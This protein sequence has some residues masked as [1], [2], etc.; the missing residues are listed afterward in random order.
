MELFCAD[1]VP[2]ATLPWQPRAGAFCTTV[3]CKLTL[4]LDPGEMGLAS[5]QDPLRDADVYREGGGLLFASDM[6]PT[7][8]RAD[9]VLVGSAFAPIGAPAQT[10]TARLL[11][12]SLDKSIDVHA[13]R[14][15]SRDGSSRQGLPFTRMPLVDERAYGGPGTWNPVG[16]RRDVRADGAAG[17]MKWANLT[18]KNARDDGRMLAVEP[19]GFGP[20]PP[21]WPVRWARLGRHEAFADAWA[22]RAEVAPPDFDFS[23]FNV[24]PMDQ[25][26]AV[27]EDDAQVLLEN[28]DATHPRLETRL[29]GLAPT[30]WLE[31]PGKVAQPILMRPDTL[32]IDTDRG[33]CTLT[34]RASVMLSRPDAPGRI[35][36]DVRDVQVDT[37]PPHLAARRMEV[38]DE[39]THN[40]EVRPGPALPFVGGPPRPRAP[41]GALRSTTGLPFLGGGAATVEPPLPA[42]RPEYAPR[43]KVEPKAAGRLAEG[44]AIE[45]LWLAPEVMPRIRRRKAWK[46][47]L[48]E[49]EEK[50][51]DPEL[52]D[53]EL[54]S[55]P[56]VMENRR[57]VGAIL[58]GADPSGP[59][60][61]REVFREGISNGAFTAK[62]ALCAGELA[63]VFDEVKLLEALV[64]AVTPLAADEERLRGVLKSANEFLGKPGASSLPGVADGLSAKMKEVL[65]QV[66]K[67]QA[68]EGVTAQV[69]RS[70]LE[71]R[72]YQRRMVFGG[73]HLRGS[74][75]MGGGSATAAIP[76][77]FPEAITTGLPM[78]TRFQARILV[79]VHPQVDGADPPGVALRGVSLGRVLHFSGEGRRA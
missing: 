46:A 27:L 1:P 43:P 60:E 65:R 34:Y 74:M 51:L 68:L 28:L 7:K 29:P 54:S 21:T 22:F 53:P 49:I 26:V 77:Y 8:P 62:M 10:L 17:L 18:Q 42:W 67:G 48:D 15:I 2:V 72:A 33:V 44:E 12:G 70:A 37:V 73:R 76:V 75:T 40:P 59:A 64:A 55:T 32:W 63:F 36:V 79:E 13:D 19:V 41:E 35:V 4:V 25:Q 61:L 71:Q 39:P 9:I 14:S 20:I 78:M 56:A 38:D 66:W 23:F 47:V 57:D 58:S 11:V 52:D 5:E 3:I 50:P 24:A 45:L 6:A 69:E 31:Q 30:A 16:V